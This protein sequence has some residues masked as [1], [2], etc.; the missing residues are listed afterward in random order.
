MQGFLLQQPV[1][2]RLQQ[3]EAGSILTSL[4]HQ[5]GL[6]MAAHQQVGFRLTTAAGRQQLLH[7]QA[8]SP[9]A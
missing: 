4:V 7:L 8:V 3:Q 9:H 6:R 2:Q 5:L 1:R